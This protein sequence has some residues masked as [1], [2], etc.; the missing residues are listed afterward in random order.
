VF[1]YPAPK[2]PSPYVQIHPWPWHNT[3]L[4]STQASELS[5]KCLCMYLSHESVSQSCIW[6]LLVNLSHNLRKMLLLIK[7]AHANV[8]PAPPR[9][10]KVIHAFILP[11]LS[12]GRLVVLSVGHAMAT[13]SGSSL[14][15]SDPQAD[16]LPILTSTLT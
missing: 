11:P 3:F 15:E 16:L 10:V 5:C 8:H 6:R 7:N 1:S 4:P 14:L 9:F 12:L 2:P 13:M